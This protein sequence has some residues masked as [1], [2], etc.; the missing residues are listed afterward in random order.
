MWKRFKA[1][2]IKRLGGYTKEEYDDWSRIPIV[3]PPIIQEV[4]RT[5][6]LHADRVVRYEEVVALGATQAEIHAKTYIREALSVAMLPHIK[7][8]MTRHPNDFQMIVEGVLTVLE[9]G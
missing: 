5:V 2:L 1:W 7:W 9:Q 3:R 6:D 4:H 8:R